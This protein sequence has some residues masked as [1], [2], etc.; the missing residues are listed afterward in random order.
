MTDTMIAPTEK[1]SL[2]MEQ[3][4]TLTGPLKGEKSPGWVAQL[5]E[6]GLTRFRKL[7]I[8]T[9]KDE[10]WK[11]TNLSAVA[12]HRYTLSAKSALSPAQR[13]DILK[14]Y[15]GKAD[16]NIVFV[17]GAFD[18]ELSN[19]GKIPPQGSLPAVGIEV[20]TLQEAAK[21]DPAAVQ[22]I[23]AH[24]DPQKDSAFVALNK[25][26]TQEGVYIHIKDK[27]IANQLICI[28]HV[29]EAP[30]EQIATFPHA[31]IRLGKSSEA[32]VLETH[33][34]LNDENIYLADPL[35]DV[36]LEENATLHYVK[37]QK[38]SLKAYHVGTTRVWQKR[39]STFNGFSLVAGALI[40][41]NNLDVV[42]NGE[43]AAAFLNGLYSVYKNQHVDNHTSVDHRV[44]KATSNQLYKGVLNDAARAV[45]NGKIFVQPIAQQT[46]SYQLNKNLLL[47]KDCQVD[48]KPQLE[49]FA[50][51]VK[52]THGA[53]I[54]QLNED[55][56]FY[57]QARGVPRKIAT[58]ILTQGFVDDIL[59]RL[60]RDS[61]REQAARMVAP[62]LEVLEG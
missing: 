47:G 42:I 39:D 33:V 51:D 8:P 60:T 52:C 19:L 56:I 46:N 35:T 20:S 21:N 3:L 36:F 12:G 17:N 48:T 13:K 6:E 45:F 57:L 32:S 34:G 43:G 9:V 44:P 22:E 55:E 15:C 16:V 1:N 7:G 14:R 10:E 2:F 53:T 29:T 38:E 40:T 37:A 41:R 28:L 50:D 4:D 24:Y 54:G 5:R 11:Y 31:F 49:I 18:K 61:V 58:R 23:W 59:N 26:L 30:G 27:I 62:S 25:A